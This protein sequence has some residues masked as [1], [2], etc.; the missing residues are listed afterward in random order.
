MA[1][2]FSGLGEKLVNKLA[3]RKTGSFIFTVVM[4]VSLSIFSFAS[5]KNSSPRCSNIG[6][7]SGLTSENAKFLMDLVQNLRGDLES[8]ALKLSLDRKVKTYINSEVE[9]GAR[10]LAFNFYQSIYSL[11]SQKLVR[12][13]AKETEN[14]SR[15]KSAK[16][17]S[18]IIELGE[19]FGPGVS[20]VPVSVMKTF[21][22]FESSSIG[23]LEGKEYSLGPR[24]KI[25]FTTTQVRVGYYHLN[26]N[27]F[28][29]L[30]K[31][32]STL[33]RFEI[34]NQN[35]KIELVQEIKIGPKQDILE[36]NIN[37]SE[38]YFLSSNLIFVKTL[39]NEIQLIDLRKIT[40]SEFTIE[41]RD[42][43]TV[44][45]KIRDIKMFDDQT[46]FIMGRDEVVIFRIDKNRSIKLEEKIRIT[47]HFEEF[48]IESV[49][50]ISDG[51]YILL[52]SS[53]DTKY[54]WSFENGELGPKQVFG[55]KEIDPSFDLS[56]VAFNK[57]RALVDTP[58][59]I[60]V[61]RN[62]DGVYKI[63]EQFNL[64][65]KLESMK[66]SDRPNFSF[67]GLERILPIENGKFLLV[68]VNGEAIELG[69]KTLDLSDFM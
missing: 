6:G 23:S 61:Y 59:G 33:F 64:E 42:L 29:V 52:R 22:K 2:Y 12:G 40:K 1:R 10:D 14:R 32:N 27:N 38:L 55:G 18:D 45:F 53:S 65:H 8:P 63:S 20:N 24:I 44:D 28:Y 16:L 15:V 67:S 56:V 37:A 41:D 25:R 50:K 69:F 11:R 39:K 36:T 68:N 47:E 5:N 17:D 57:K 7:I 26:S 51:H 19:S 31:Y 13:S 43:R 49:S 30:D 58:D 4:L 3:L 46:G 9:I 48:P 54:I 66:E 34:D 21:H 35:K 60:F 62:R